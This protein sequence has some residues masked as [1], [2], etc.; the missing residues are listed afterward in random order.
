MRRP[1]FP[2]VFQLLILAALVVPAL[3]FAAASVQN[4][5]DLQREWRE[6]VQRTASVFDEHAQKVVETADLVLALVNDRVGELSWEQI[7]APETSAY[8]AHVQAPLEQVVSIWVTDATGRV[9][10]G[11]APFGKSAMLDR[12][13]FF[14]RQREADQGTFVGESFIGRATGR[15][16]IGISRRLRRPSGGFDGIVHVSLDPAYFDRFFASAAPAVGHESLLIRGDGAIL[17]REPVPGTAAAAAD[18]KAVKPRVSPPRIG[19]V[20]GAPYEAQSEL[21]GVTRLYALRQIGTRPLFVRFG[22]DRSAIYAPWRENVALFGLL[23]LA[24]SGTFVLLSW[25]ALR[26]AQAEQAALARL[27]HESE[28]RLLIEQRLS[29]AQ[30]MEA[31]GL[32]T[33]G[34]AHD[35]NN[36]L[37]TVILNLEA[38]GRVRDLPPAVRRYAETAL[39]V[40]ERGAQL[41]ASVMGFSRRE[42]RADEAI[43]VNAQIEDL[44]ALLRHGVGVRI[45]LDLALDPNLPLCAAEPAQL[46]S[47]ILNLAVNARD[48]MPDGGTMTVA[49][50]AVTIDAAAATGPDMRPGNFVAVSVADTGS[51]MPPEIVARAFEPFFTTKEAG[52]G[53]GLGL[54][55]VLAYARQSGGSATVE[56]RVAG[57]PAG[58]PGT[59]VTLF[60][61]ASRVEGA[62][63]RPLETA[64]ASH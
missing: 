56:S 14:E 3:L 62:A 13:D 18:A 49:T 63:A 11:S 15:A 20:E 59:C 60:L 58:P 55:Q 17:A 21:D 1:S 10:A 47:A 39:D 16:S 19:P 40:S 25:L 29:Q 57:D 27:R 46:G 52:R 44:A 43:D 36:L 45:T 2:R 48:A 26:R 12:H 32:L 22:I 6:R 5:I 35:F 30:K 8:L 61:P 33:G 7:D 53:T 64:R 4:R 50:R 38:I 23:A 24:V 31:V 34:I 9:R 41:I 54:A 37:T 42:D 51:G 28:Q